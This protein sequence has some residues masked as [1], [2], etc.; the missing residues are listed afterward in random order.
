MA[1]I[2]CRQLKR[3]LALCDWTML[4]NTA[5]RSEHSPQQN[6]LLDALPAADWVRLCPHLELVYLP[7]GRVLFEPQAK[8]RHVYF[9]VDALVALL[10]PLES[11][12]TD[13]VSLVGRE[14]IV[15]I[16]TFMGGE[17][18]PRRAVVECA[19]HAYR[20]PR[21]VVE[22]EFLRHGDLTQVLLHY[23][24]SLVN[25]MAQTVACNR[26]HSAKQRLS[27]W[28]LMCLD[29]M[30][31]RQ[32]ALSHGL[33]A[34]LLGVRRESI[35]AVAA[36]LRQVGA[37]DYQRGQLRVLD[38]AVLQAHACECYQVVKADEDHWDA[39]RPRHAIPRVCG[40]TAAGRPTTLSLV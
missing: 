14:G 26:H 28:L 39:T 16:V 23:V 30:P 20:L 12:A 11:G 17:S 6:A 34:Q 5:I 8:L 2:R 36:A 3:V 13:E 40:Q 31:G 35:S 22:D 1:G 25:Q 21:L 29:R 9:P 24:L 38:R 10:S 27:R 33:L 19:G 4:V 7:F 32:F 37:I 18:T 15:G